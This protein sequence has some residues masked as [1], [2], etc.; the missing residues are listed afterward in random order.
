[1]TITLYKYLGERE[2][3]DKSSDLSFILSTSGKFKGDVSITSP[4][5]ILTLPVGRV[6]YVTDE[7]GNEIEDIIAIDET[8]EVLNFNYFYIEEFRRYYFLSSLSVSSGNV[9]IV[10]GSVDPLYSFKDQILRN[11]AMVDR[12]EFDYDTMQEDGA[13]PLEIQKEVSEF[14]PEESDDS[15]VNSKFQTEFEDDDIN[16][17]NF[18]LTFINVAGYGRVITPDNIPGLPSIDSQKFDDSAGNVA[19]CLDQQ[20]AAQLA[21]DTLG[22]YSAY[23]TFLKSLVA[24]P[25][26]FREFSDYPH[27][28]N[29][30]IYKENL[31]THQ[32]DPK[33]LNASGCP[34]ASDSPYLVMADFVLP[35][36]SS[37]LDLNPYSHYEIY[38]PFYGYHEININ[39]IG[40]HRIIVYYSLNYQSGGGEVYLWDYTA[41]RLIFTAS[42]QVGVSIS[43][44]STN[45]Q[46]QQAQK[47]AAQLNLILGLIGSG[48][49]AVGSAAS[50]NVLGAIG[51]GLTAV[52]S[53]TSYINQTSLMFERAQCTHNGASG[54]LYSPLDVRLKITRTKARNGLNMS[55]YA[56]QYG[57]PLRQIRTLSD[58]HGF[59]AISS[60]HLEGV[61]ALQVEKDSIISSLL[62]GVIL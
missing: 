31:Q 6:E 21:L 50:G 3:V 29:V 34:L 58:L 46:E 35:A 33:V 55:E 40:S 8:G 51:S 49:G 17:K 57:R 43:L 12:N 24:F 56:H 28:E 39:Q 26:N 10:T 38:I 59:T 60:I 18:I 62:S 27:F 23:A 48:I 36:I 19:F 11:S 5:L 41:S 7:N 16:Y 54:G 20:N 42:C 1:M 47:N 52:K 61:E 32:Y 25:V 9:A 13:L 30:T 2:K 53:V 4:V 14:V 44:A 22:D 37:F 15:K 45:A